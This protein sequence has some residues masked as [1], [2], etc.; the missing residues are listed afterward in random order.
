M[1]GYGNTPPAN[2]QQTDTQQTNAPQ[3]NAPQTED[4]SNT[5]DDSQQCGYCH[6]WFSVSDGSYAAHIAEEN[7]SLGLPQGTEYVQCPTCGYSFP[8]GSLYDNHVCV[9][10]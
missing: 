8:K 7:A 9:T 10:N 3:T 1:Y 2:Q 6:Q 5:V 4:P